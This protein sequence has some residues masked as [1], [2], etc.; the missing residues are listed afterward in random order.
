MTKEE[1]N[2][3]RTG[4]VLENKQTKARYVLIKSGGTLEPVTQIKPEHISN[5]I[6]E[7][8]VLVKAQTNEYNAR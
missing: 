2:Q 1:F 3:L 5:R 4:D 6:E 8:N 7:F